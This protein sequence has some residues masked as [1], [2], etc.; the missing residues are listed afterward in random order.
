MVEYHRIRL[1]GL[2]SLHICNLANVAYGY[3]KI[4]E[5]HGAEVAL[6]CHDLR[7]LMSQPEWDDLELRAEEFPDE[8]N[9]YD[10]EADFGDYRRPDW[11]RSVGIRTSGVVDLPGFHE[12]ESIEGRPAPGK[13][14]PRRIA[15]SVWNRLPSALR[16]RLKRPIKA[17][18]FAGRAA[19]QEGGFREAYRSYDRIAGDRFERLIAEAAKSGPDFAI[20]AEMLASFQQ[21]AWWAR[22][23]AEG[24][25]VVF[26][27]VYAPIYSL[28]A[29][30]KPFVSVEIGTMRDIPFDGTKYGRLLALAYRKSP[31]VL[32]TNPDVVR[33]AGELGV[34]SYSFCP[35]PLDED[36]YR[37]EPGGEFRRSLLEEGHADYVLFAPA[38]QNWEIK[39]N[40]RY[41]RA[42][43]SLTQDDG[44]K[45][46]LVIPGWGQEIERSQRLC[47]DLGI[48]E[49]VRW[50]PPQSEALLVKYYRS[51]DFV[52]DQFDLGVFGLT[53]PKAMACGAVVVTSY[54][55]S[56][57]D[58]CF[59]EHPPLV[60]ATTAGDIRAA[61]SELCRDEERRRELGTRAR[62]WVERHHSKQ[63]IRSILEEAMGIA[64]QRHRKG[65]AS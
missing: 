6:R 64:C 23:E 38:R 12:T 3:C 30:E 10:N 27:Y 40:D 18:L 26:S 51:A 34:E 13:K 15:Q 55:P 33:Q 24:F 43:Q 14:T 5:Q 57:H 52:L 49:H 39:R 41:L 63:R 19:R 1:S 62:R 31:H 60:P 4:L 2:R 28:L 48:E 46:M 47:R 16:A 56:L 29:G 36:I 42:F 54:E 44:L 58:W 22:Q 21:H 59:D 65:A 17:A 8:W 37:P 32:I 11:Y 53:T 20:D 25:D 50:I 45:A 7:H 35:H 61:V 9:F